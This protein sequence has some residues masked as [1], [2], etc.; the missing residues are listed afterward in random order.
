MNKFKGANYNIEFI[1]YK[2]KK[3]VSIGKISEFYNVSEQTIMNDI[4]E[5]LNLKDVKDIMACIRAKNEFGKPIDK[6]IIRPAKYYKSK[7]YTYK[8]FL[9]MLKAS[10]RP[11]SESAKLLAKEIFQE[12]KDIE[13]NGNKDKSTECN[14]EIEI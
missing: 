2:L 14:D 7:G 1:I 5:H 6:S 12:N 3:G 13:Q 4:K 10:N 9:E 11:F 8:E